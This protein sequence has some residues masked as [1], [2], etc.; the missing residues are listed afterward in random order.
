MLRALAVPNSR[1][2]I[3]RFRFSHVKASIFYDTFPKVMSLCFP[4][5]PYKPNKEDWFDPIV[6]LKGLT[7]FGDSKFFVSG[8]LVLGGF[9]VGSDFMWDA[10]VNLGYQWT[11][12]FSTTFGYRYLDVDYENG[13]FL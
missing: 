4:G 9:G 1:H 3:L 5:C 10:N 8:F 12:T 7:P 13:D 6:G 2:A 11:E